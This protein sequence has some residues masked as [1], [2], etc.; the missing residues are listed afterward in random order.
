MTIRSS[1]R[2]FHWVAI[3]VVA[4]G[5]VADPAGTGDASAAPPSDAVVLPSH[6]V[7]PPPSSAPATDY[8]P[9]YRE[10]PPVPKPGEDVSFY[11]DYLLYERT[12][13]LCSGRMFG[14]WVGYADGELDALAKDLDGASG[15]LDE[16]RLT[17]L[18][19]IEE[20]LAAWSLTSIGLEFA[21]VAHGFGQIQPD[22][23]V[24]F[25]MPSGTWWAPEFL[26]IELRDGRGGWAYSGSNF[27]EIEDC[28]D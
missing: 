4:V 9:S 16:Y 6:D 19:T 2:T 23:A 12:G 24:Q 25:G 20:T 7:T 26:P 5:C 8:R 3:V 28:S 15:F 21:D 17:Y 27:R 11:V 18:G 10:P 1:L 14:E 13:E 22:R